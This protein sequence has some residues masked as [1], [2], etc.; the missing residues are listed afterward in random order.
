MPML[1]LLLAAQSLSAKPNLW[2]GRLL[3]SCHSAL[4]S[5]PDGLCFSELK[6]V[7]EKVLEGGY[8]NS[9]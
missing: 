7:W 6:E 1:S 2:K 4:A 9:R 3:S 8:V 5:V